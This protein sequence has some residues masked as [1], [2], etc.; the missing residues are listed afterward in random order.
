MESLL[1]SIEELKMIKTIQIQKSVFDDEKLPLLSYWRFKVDDV[2]FNQVGY[3][4]NYE[5]EGATLIAVH[6]AGSYSFEKY[7]YIEELINGELVIE[8]V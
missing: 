5:D 2:H 3:I 7:Y 8:P 6:S 1:L 4:A